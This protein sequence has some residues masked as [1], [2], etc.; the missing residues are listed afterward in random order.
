ALR[1]SYETGGA[2]P[3]ALPSLEPAA[4]VEDFSYIS[5]P[6]HPPLCEASSSS[7]ASPRPPPFS[8]LYSAPDP[9]V[10][11]FKAGVTEDPGASFF[12]AFA[13]PPPSPS[14]FLSL[15]EDLDE[16][17]S[18]VAETKA[19]LESV[20]KKGESSG[21]T[22]DD[23]EPPPPYTEGYSPLQSFSYVMAAAGGAASIITQ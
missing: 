11:R 14:L 22:P 16:S 20:E 23:S 4:I 10:D 19:A 13:P 12:P 3:T 6:A 5:P 2:P 18:V 17:S 7:H 8:S 1:F 21:K 15:P 9:E